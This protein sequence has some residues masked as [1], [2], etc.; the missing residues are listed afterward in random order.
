MSVSNGAC[1]TTQDT[2]VQ[3]VPLVLARRPENLLV[4]SASRATVP[5]MTSNLAAAST[6]TAPGVAAQRAARTE[7]F[8]IG[9]CTGAWAPLVPFAK[10][11]LRLSDDTLGLL[12]LCMGIGSIIAIPLAGALAAR[13]GCRSVLIVPTAV[14]CVALPLLIV[15]PGVAAFACVLA[16]FGAS[17]G[18][19][20][21]VM[22]I[23]AFLVERASGRAMISG[24]RG[25]FSGGGIVG[26]GVVRALLSVGASPLTVER[27]GRGEGAMSSF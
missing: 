9:V 24:F 19:A 11:R 3:S 21:C 2:R 20:D 6:V 7:F 5:P 14:L 25:L 18:S 22:N 12:L 15:V 17:I 26:A 1:R 27:E 23:Q 8:L 10:A 16:V 13:V 4:Q